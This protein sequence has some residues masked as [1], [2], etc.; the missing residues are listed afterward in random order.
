MGGLSSKST[1]SLDKSQTTFTEEKVPDFYYLKK[2]NELPDWFKSIKLRS[3]NLQHLEKVKDP[4]SGKGE[5]KFSHKLNVDKTNAEL[6]RKISLDCGKRCTYSYRGELDDL[7]FPKG[8]LGE[9]TLKPR[10]KNEM[11]MNYAEQVCLSRCTAK[12]FQGK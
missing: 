11:A 2:P 10:D 8:Q 9:G 3:E 12:Y 7:G 6:A 5:I 1:S 4:R